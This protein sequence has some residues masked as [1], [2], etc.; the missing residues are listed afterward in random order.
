MN[1]NGLRRTQLSIADET[2]S[3]GLCCWQSCIAGHA[4]RVAGV[5]DTHASEIGNV[6]IAYLGI[7]HEQVSLF[8]SYGAYDNRNNDR[9]LAIARIDRLIAQDVASQPDPGFTPVPTATP[10]ETGELVAA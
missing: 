4:C 10:V 1:I 2:L 9:Q 3:F 7:S 6:A 5:P 8:H